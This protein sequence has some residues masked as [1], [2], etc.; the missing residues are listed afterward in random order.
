MLQSRLVRIFMA[1][2]I[3]V[4]VFT[5]I[6]QSF[7]D[8][9]KYQVFFYSVSVLSALFFTIEYV[10]RII[11]APVEYPELSVWKARKKYMTSFMGIVDLIAILPFT[12]PYL[13]KA[14]VVRDMIELGRIFLI[15][16][17]LRYTKSFRMI[18]EVLGSVKYEL[19]T[20]SSFAAMIVSFC[21]ILMYYI[22][23]QAQP[24]AFSDIG[25]GF[26]WAMITFTT[27][28]YGDIYP[29]TA[30]GKILA[31]GMAIVGIVTLTLPTA[32]ISGAMM[33]RL[34]VQRDEYERKKEQKDTDKPRL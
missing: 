10:L 17:I 16:K 14:K 13:F 7:P 6:L 9:E 8:M 5:V 2:L 34:R 24:E 32:I 29:V 25:Q 21:A 22:E 3:A 26:W 33:D 30:L 19:L 20:A 31:S 28:G 12:A 11:C 18:R 15:L 23:R 1:T 4:G 27:V